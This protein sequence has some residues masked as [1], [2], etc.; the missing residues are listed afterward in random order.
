MSNVQ[1]TFVFSHAKRDQIVAVKFISRVDMNRDDVMN[2]QFE[3]VSLGVS[4]FFA[5]R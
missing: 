2:L 4:L 3:V 5:P 1:M